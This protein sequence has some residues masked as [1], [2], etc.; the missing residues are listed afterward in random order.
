VVVVPA[1]LRRGIINSFIEA[2]AVDSTR[3]MTLQQLGISE[4]PVFLRL[5][6]DGKVISIDGFRYYLNIDKVRTF[7]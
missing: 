3:A 4:T 2:G 7:R 5:I 1:I 6:K